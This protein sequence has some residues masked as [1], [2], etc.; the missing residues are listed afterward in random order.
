MHILLAGPCSTASFRSEINVPLPG[1]PSGQIQTPINPLAVELV[2]RGH[3]VHVVT[4]DQAISEPVRY[5]N[6]MFSISYIPK[7]LRARHLA[8]DL[9]A[10]EIRALTHEFTAV[11]PD[12]IHA[13]WTYEFAEA[14]VRARIPLLVTAHDAPLKNVYVFRDLYRVF[15]LVM[16]IR[17]LARVKHLTCVSRMQLP[18]MRALGYLRHI[19]VVPNG[20]DLSTWEVSDAA[21]T[22]DPNAIIV[23]IGNSSGLKNVSASVM[24][25]RKIRAAIPAATLHLFGSG[26]DS[27]FVK[28]EV[29]VFGH[30]SVSHPLLKEF[31]QKKASLLIH[32]SRQEICPV[33][34]IEAMASG[35]PCIAGRRSGGVP[36]LFRNSLSNCLVDIENFD[37]I[38]E[39]AISILNSKSTWISLSH[40]VQ[41]NVKSNFSIDDVTS[42]Y[43]ALYHSIIQSNGTIAKR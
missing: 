5:S 14:G 9:F 31:L 25:F 4:L 18:H 24:A 34:I 13:H 29:N 27:E 7:R 3:R 23:T 20:I 42:R 2:R 15:R 36:D 40:Q 16:A 26:L 30:G 12:I 10:K 6:D 43:E 11:Q 17:T 35:L 1:A 19:D 39:K 37:E 32:P 41:E 38:A 22:A 8:L 21:R 33:A 28:G